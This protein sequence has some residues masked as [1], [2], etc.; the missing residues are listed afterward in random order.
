MVSIALLFSC[1]DYSVIRYVIGVDEAGRGPLAGP[2]A[3]GAV[4]VP[5]EFD[6]LKAFPNVK[7]S[8]MLTP[9]A[10]EA[11]YE[12]LVARSRAGELRFCVRFSYQSYIDAFGITKA[13][14]RAL[15]SGVRA[16]ASEPRGVRVLL[17][18]LLRAPDEYEQETIVHGDALVPIISL[19]SVAAKVRRD[20]LMKRLAKQFPKYGFEKHKGYGTLQHRAAIAHFGLSE[21]HRATFCRKLLV[22][23]KLV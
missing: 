22:T 18:G 12:E 13:V 19:A 16:L 5:E 15:W 17:D 23:E 21:I 4:L 9:A 6:V 2:V 11:I 3:V 8:K 7:D 20:A 14:R 10:R 1:Y